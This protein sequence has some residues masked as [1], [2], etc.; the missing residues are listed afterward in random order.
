MRATTS[1]RSLLL[2]LIVVPV[3]LSVFTALAYLSGW[4]RALRFI[5]FVPELPGFVVSQTILG[6]HHD[7][8]T[9]LLWLVATN[10]IIYVAAI[11]AIS[12]WIEYRRAIHK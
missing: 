10:T 2:S 5:F 1:R 4:P 12:R 9:L 3:A 6:R 8:R 7:Q 11:Y